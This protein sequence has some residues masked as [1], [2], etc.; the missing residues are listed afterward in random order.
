MSYF[1]RE[2]RE[3]VNLDSCELIR[4]QFEL[5][6]DYA[7]GVALDYLAEVTEQLLPPAEPNERFFRLL[8][9]GAGSLARARRAGRRCGR[10]S[11][12]F[13][14]VGGAAVGFPAGACG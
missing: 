7:A 2:N 13:S 8:A 11:T 12:Y 14:L 1:Q 6:S 10:R 9:G 3:L 4:S 5:L